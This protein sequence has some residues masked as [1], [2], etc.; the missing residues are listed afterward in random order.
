MNYEQKY[1]KYKTK[2]LQLKAQMGGF[3]VGNVVLVNGTNAA[4]RQYENSL[5]TILVA[6]NGIFLVKFQG[7]VG[8]NHPTFGPNTDE[9]HSNM[10]KL[11]GNKLEKLTLN[12]IESY[13]NIYKE[14]V[15]KELEHK[16]A[17][18]SRNP[19]NGPNININN[20]SSGNYLKNNPESKLSIKLATECLAYVY[21]IYRFFENIRNKHTINDKKFYEILDELK[22]LFDTCGY[23]F[24]AYNE[25][26]IEQL[27]ISL[28]NQEI[29]K[30]Y[31]S[32]SV[33]DKIYN[34]FYE[35]FTP[36]KRNH[37]I[38]CL[39]SAATKSSNK[40]I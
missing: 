33:A 40:T 9:V 32:Q 25:Y 23:D 6:N 7:N 17:Y 28:F 8:I 1:L 26:N 15:R 37:L 11:T 5:A 13:M 20:K 16:Y 27:K 35:K 38:I 12:K 2:Y 31:P 3:S 10:I 30:Q 21:S 29:G 19:S 34:K 22:Q 14:L 18:E 39:S 24:S 36:E 4:G